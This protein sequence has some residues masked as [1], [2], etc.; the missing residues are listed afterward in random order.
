MLTAGWPWEVAGQVWIKQH[1]LL[2]GGGT[3]LVPS[4]VY[5]AILGHATELSCWDTVR[6]SVFGPREK[7]VTCHRWSGTSNEMRVTGSLG[8]PVV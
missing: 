3:E 1:L 4:L 8:G 2:L 5:H 7:A 6:R